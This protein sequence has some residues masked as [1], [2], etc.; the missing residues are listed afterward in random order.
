[1]AQYV[2]KAMAMDPSLAEDFK[3]LADKTTPSQASAIG[4]GMA[5]AGRMW[6][7]VNPDA[8]AQFAN[9]VGEI[10]NPQI[11]R[12]FKAI[13]PRTEGVGNYIVPPQVPTP[14][15]GNTPVGTEA[16]RITSEAMQQQ[17]QP[18]LRRRLSPQVRGVKFNNNQGRTNDV[19]DGSGFGAA[20]TTTVAEEEVRD[21]NK[22]S[23]GSTSDGSTETPDDTGDEVDSP[24]E[25]F[26]DED[27]ED[28][29]GVPTSPTS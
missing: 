16:D 11:N 6:N 8:A 4:A 3:S 1:M 26:I 2:T 7:A 15:L 19:D 9:K 22:T 25:D 17:R 24:G 20:V 21:N 27:E 10:E 13:G 28:N 18:F 5:R 29:G 12:T 14:P 23:S